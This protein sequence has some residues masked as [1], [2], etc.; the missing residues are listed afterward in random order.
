MK[1]DNIVIGKKISKHL[2][3]FEKEIEPIDLLKII[4]F[5]AYRGKSPG[6]LYEH[7]QIFYTRSDDITRKEFDY[8]HEKL[9]RDLNHLLDR[10]TR[11]DLIS[12]IGSAIKIISST[13]K[14]EIM[15]EIKN[16][17][18]LLFR[19]FKKDYIENYCSKWNQFKKQKIFMP[20]A[21]DKTKSLVFSLSCKCTFLSNKPYL[22]YWRLG[23]KYEG[24]DLEKDFETGVNNG[25][26]MINLNNRDS[27][28]IKS[29]NK[30]LSQQ[31][32][33]YEY[34]LRAENRAICVEDLNLKKASEITYQLG[35]FDL[36]DYFGL[37]KGSKFKTFCEGLKQRQNPDIYLNCLARTYLVTA[38]GYSIYSGTAY[39]KELFEMIAWH[40][41]IEY[42]KE[43]RILCKV[44]EEETCETL[45]ALWDMMSESQ[46]RGAFCFVEIENAQDNAFFDY[47]D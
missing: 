41:K 15:H 45:A 21:S 1:I 23:D 4:R 36:V 13:T 5:M 8:V 6:Y 30:F 19:F 38:D 29:I 17:M 27:T 43:K 35:L 10:Y 26:L 39:P 46:Y 25:C 28:I 33:D 16:N 22:Q 7:N 9:S 31:E 40:L 2:Y 42:I 47:S 32:K 24:F 3:Q 12:R 20:A 44:V 14:T 18:N 34:G 11:D 37:R